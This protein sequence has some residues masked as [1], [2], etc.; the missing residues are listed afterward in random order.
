MKKTIWVI[1]RKE[2]RK[3]EIDGHIVMKKRLA[4]ERCGAL[5]RF[6]GKDVHSYRKATVEM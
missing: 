5:D 1:V 6:Y 2:N 4:I 3:I